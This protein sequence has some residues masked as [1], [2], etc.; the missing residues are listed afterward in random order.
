[1]GAHM[2][3]KH[4]RS[5]TA[6][7]LAD[8]QEEN[9]RLKEEVVLLR[10]AA[11]RADR[12]A[13]LESQLRE[14]RAR[15]LALEKAESERARLH[16]MVET[17]TER[18]EEM[19]AEAARVEG[20]HK[21]VF[22]ALMRQAPGSSQEARLAWVLSEVDT[23]QSAIVA[24]NIAHVRRLLGDQAVPPALLQKLGVH[25]AQHAG[26]PRVGPT[27]RSVGVPTAG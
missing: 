1:M 2:K 25:S 18:V 10:A 16:R 13:A 22:L 23:E 20:A 17:L 19:T 26:V 12:S 5:V 6:N 4:G 21:R 11:G 9:N 15:N 8:A 24:G 14:M 7:A 3:G 27:K